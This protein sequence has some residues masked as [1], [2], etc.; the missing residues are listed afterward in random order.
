MKPAAAC[1]RKR[2]E[3]NPD[4]PWALITGTRHRLIHDYFEVDLDLVWKLA[5]TGIVDLKPKIT[6]LLISLS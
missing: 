6:A 1:R 4:I 3:A 2:V 5:T